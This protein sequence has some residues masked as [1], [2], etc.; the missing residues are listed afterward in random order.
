MEEMRQSLKIVRQI[1]DNLPSGP[2]QSLDKAICLPPKKEVYTNIEGLM[3]H[4]MLVM[5]GVTPPVGEIYSSTEA[6]NGE[7]GFYVISDGGKNPYRVKCRPPC[8]A[9]Y[10]SF[11]EVIQN[12]LISD[13]IAELGAMNIIAGELDR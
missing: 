12:K 11:S 8:F 4:F 7:L 1:L 13:A 2:V 6:A 9:I 5:K 3:N 10:Q